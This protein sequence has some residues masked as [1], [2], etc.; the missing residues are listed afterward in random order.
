M[1]TVEPASSVKMM[2]TVA[3]WPRLSG[4]DPMINPAEAAR[5]KFFG[6]TAASR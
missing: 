1:R 2:T 5:S 6:F 4:A 3:S